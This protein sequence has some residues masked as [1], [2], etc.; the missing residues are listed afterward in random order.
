MRVLSTGG[1]SAHIVAC[2]A[3]GTLRA[4]DACGAAGPLIKRA[5]SL[6]AL[7]STPNG[8]GSWTLAFCDTAGN[9]YS[10]SY[11]SGAFGEPQCLAIPSKKIISLAI[12]IVKGET[13][14]FAGL[15]DNHIAVIVGMQIVLR[16]SGHGNWV[17]SMDCTPFYTKDDAPSLLL[18]TGASDRSVRV[19]KISPARA[20]R[21]DEL[22][23]LVRGEEEFCVTTGVKYQI[24]CETI[25]YGHESMVHSV[26]WD[27]RVTEMT[28]FAEV[29]LIS[30]AADHTLRLWRPGD[31]GGWFSV[32]QIGDISSFGTVG[33]DR[34]FGFFSGLVF[35]HDGRERIIAHGS[36]GTIVEFSRGAGEGYEGLKWE[37][38]QPI[39]SGH[40]LK[41]S[42]CTW[43]RE[44]GSFLITTSV[45]KTTRIWAPWSSLGG[46]WYEI[47]RPQIH[48]YEMQAVDMAD[49]THFL[50]IGD[51]KIIR[52]FEAPNSFS[53]RL[54]LSTSTL[55]A[56]TDM[57]NEA[58]GDDPV[59]VPALGL[60]N[61][62]GIA[63][64]STRPVPTLLHPP[65]EYDLSR[66]TL[67][68]ETDKLYGHG[69]EVYSVAVSHSGLLAASASK[70]ANAEDAVVRFWKRAE[71]GN[72]WKALPQTIKC[73]RST[74][75]KLA[76]SPDGRYLLAVSRDRH[77]SLTKLSKGEGPDLDLNLELV[78][79]EMAHLRIIW[80]AAWSSD[81]SFFVT[82]SR[83]RAL[84]TWWRVDEKWTEDVSGRVELPHGITAAAISPSISAN[85]HHLAVGLEDGAIIVFR[86]AQGGGRWEEYL[87]LP[88]R[89]GGGSSTINDLKW[90]PHGGYLCAVSDA[91][92]VYAVGE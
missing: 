18:A 26:R 38:E 16:V 22:V 83:D 7:A 1:R 88:A 59:I 10:T 91:V 62:A 9:I 36:T 85:S 74:V 20:R 41:I 33:D 81:S 48:G 4:W 70:A 34:S 30:A 32:A 92:Q 64:E 53:R 27:R 68:P 90:H 89:G 5:H 23:E 25:I 35:E 44:K 50:S 28:P 55:T 15:S 43:E 14:I 57:K 24:A 69:L 2:S 78:H 65:T 12:A 49:A 72:L 63:R 8:S 79:V 21:P 6:N 3:D 75:V 39:V 37:S 61:K 80:G 86:R 82:A 51:E 54:A 29:R 76:F 13:V 40:T 11:S 47:A 58:L 42:S 17:N 87:C 52:A 73:H 77:W 46:K 71:A 84:K 60:S 31:I 19:W 45:D 66:Q 67:W 56:P